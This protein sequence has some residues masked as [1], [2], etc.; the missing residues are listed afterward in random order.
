MKETVSDARLDTY[1]IIDLKLPRSV[2]NLEGTYQ[3]KKKQHIV[4]IVHIVI[5]LMVSYN[6]QLFRMQHTLAQTLP[7]PHV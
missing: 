2:Y 6:V 3:K 5:T 1:R 4:H 7:C